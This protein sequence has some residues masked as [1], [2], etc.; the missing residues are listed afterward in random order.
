MQ[1]VATLGPKEVNLGVG[2]VSRISVPT[3][4]FQIADVG[5]LILILRLKF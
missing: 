4:G 3:C 5:F 2:S 1:G